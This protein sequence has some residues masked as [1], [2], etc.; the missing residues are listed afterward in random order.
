M[1]D[2]KC[3]DERY[4]KYKDSFK[5]LELKDMHSAY[6]KLQKLT[7]EMGDLF[8]KVNKIAN[9]KLSNSLAAE[10]IERVFTNKE[11]N[12]FLE[13]VICLFLSY[14]IIKEDAT[15]LLTIP[16]E[17]AKIHELLPY[18]LND[19]EIYKWEKEKNRYKRD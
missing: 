7:N 2:F 15:C 3:Y 19:L 5:M 6:E 1:S 11:H 14:G 18:A 10:H 16:K 9:K 8:E 17:Y 4:E 12:P 13:E